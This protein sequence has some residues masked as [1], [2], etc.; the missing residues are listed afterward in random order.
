[1][2]LVRHNLDLTLFTLYT[3][4]FSANYIGR[5]ENPSKSHHKYTKFYLSCS[6]KQF[7]I[8]TEMW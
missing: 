5:N 4:L 6:L 1:M 2:K 3:N 7:S 8:F